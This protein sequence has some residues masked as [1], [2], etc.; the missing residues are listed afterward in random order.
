[1]RCAGRQGD[2]VFFPFLESPSH[3]VV[4]Y[5]ATV[6]SALSYS[7]CGKSFQSF[8]RLLCHRHVLKP[9][10]QFYRRLISSGM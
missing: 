4:A 1:M 2:K 9:T 6:H 3:P 7:D 10:D 8:K 5:K